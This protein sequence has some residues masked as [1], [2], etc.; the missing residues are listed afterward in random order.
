MGTTYIEM[1]HALWK[2]IRQ[3][4]KKLNRTLPKDPVMPLL[5]VYPGYTEAHVHAKT[6]TLMLPPVL[7]TTARKENQH[8]QGLPGWEQTHKP[9]YIY[10]MEYHRAIKKNA[11]QTLQHEHTF[12]TLC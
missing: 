6:P 12:K 9:W 2:T 1:A 7:F 10:A 8:P 11:A 3:S 5:N 4:L